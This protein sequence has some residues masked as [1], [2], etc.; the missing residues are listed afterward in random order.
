MYKYHSSGDEPWDISWDGIKLGF[1]F[2]CLLTTGLC[3]CERM[4]SLFESCNEF[5]QLHSTIR[6]H[7]HWV[8]NHVIKIPLKLGEAD[9]YKNPAP[10]PSPL[11]VWLLNICFPQ[12]SPGAARVP[13]LSV[14]DTLNVPDI[15]VTPL[16]PLRTFQWPLRTVHSFQFCVPDTPTSVLPFSTLV[17]VPPGNP[18]GMRGASGSQSLWCSQHPWHSGH[19]SRCSV[20]PGSHLNSGL[21]DTTY[22]QANDAI[23]IGLLHSHYN[24]YNASSHIPNSLRANEVIWICNTNYIL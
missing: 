21:N 17:F 13:D 10:P 11:F 4:E 22:L 1:P 7:L 6:H 16:W 14:H 19:L 12:T 8:R 24:Q 20:R 18:S 15:P 2:H 3:H 5:N 23:T 9:L